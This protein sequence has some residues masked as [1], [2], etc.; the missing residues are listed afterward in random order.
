M[1]GKEKWTG[2]SGVGFLNGM[3]FGRLGRTLSSL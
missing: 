1:K 2:R 3:G